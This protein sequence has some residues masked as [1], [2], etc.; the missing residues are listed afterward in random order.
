MVFREWDREDHEKNFCEGT[1]RKQK[2]V[3]K[4]RKVAKVLQKTREEKKEQAKKTRKLLARQAKVRQKKRF[5][6]VEQAL[7]KRKAVIEDRKEQER[8][9][10]SKLK[11]REQERLQRYRDERERIIQAGVMKLQQIECE[12]CGTKV[13]KKYMTKHLRDECPV[14]MIECGNNFC[15]IV[16]QRQDWE[17]HTY[18]EMNNLLQLEIWI[19]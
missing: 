19:Q 18:G 2:V 1:K 12:H 5:A 13:A 4:H 6:L 10:K 9:R 8:L 17:F 11:Q 7:E 3:K 16:V 14:T 15:S